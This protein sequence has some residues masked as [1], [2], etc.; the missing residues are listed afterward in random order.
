MK[1]RR[2]GEK[3]NERDKA[4]VDNK[5]ERKGDKRGKMTRVFITKKIIQHR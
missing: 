2:E 4:I 1:W 3:R 5:E